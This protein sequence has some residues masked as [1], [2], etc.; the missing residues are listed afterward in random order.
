[1]QSAS[2][3]DNIFALITFVVLRYTL[4]L[5]INKPPHLLSFKS[6]KNSPFIVAINSG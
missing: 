4:S 5:L 6:E 3:N 1:L 2:E